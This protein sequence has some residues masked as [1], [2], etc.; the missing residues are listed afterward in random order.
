MDR[1]TELL[2]AFQTRYRPALPLEHQPAESTLNL[3]IKRHSRR[4]A[5]FAPLSKVLN[6]TDGR[7]SYNEPLKLGKHIQ[8]N[9]D[10][11]QKKR[12]SDFNTS[13]EAFAHAVRVLMMGYA[14][15]SAADTI[16]WCSLDAARKHL[17]L[18]DAATRASARGFH[19]NHH[20]IVEAEMT[21]RNEWVRVAQA[22]T[23]LILSDIIE[24][25][26]QRHSIWPAVSELKGGK[27][28]GGAKKG[29]NP[30]ASSS[31]NQQGWQNNGGWQEWNSSTNQKD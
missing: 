15:V 10:G 21:A 14:L 31:S 4:S 22:E 8:I 1:R 5:E 12:N 11:A 9:L 23:Q 25:V 29:H 6:I 26:V 24:L 17:S 13:P 2:A 16:P 19:A 20:K 3:L 18:V 27:G 30:Y 7:D 28:K